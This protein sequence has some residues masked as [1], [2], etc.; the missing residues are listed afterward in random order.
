MKLLPFKRGELLATMGRVSGQEKDG[1]QLGSD[2]P[3]KTKTIE[4]LQKDLKLPD[5]ENFKLSMCLK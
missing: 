2:K 4:L 1:H 5:T 3:S